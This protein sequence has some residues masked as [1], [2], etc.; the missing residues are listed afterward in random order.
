MVLK[1][2]GVKKQLLKSLGVKK[3]KGNEY[4]KHVRKVWVLQILG[5][6]KKR[7]LKKVLKS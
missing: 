5:I 4:Q 3:L 7:V 2:L 1:S 6:K